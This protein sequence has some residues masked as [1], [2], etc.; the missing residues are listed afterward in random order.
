MRVRNAGAGLFLVALLALLVVGCVPTRADLSPVVDRGRQVVANLDTE[1]A[2]LRADLDAVRADLAMIGDAGVRARVVADL[3]R[4]AVLLERLQT[5]RDA[6][7]DVLAEAER[8]MA[9]APTTAAD[10]SG[11]ATAAG[12][13]IGGPAGAGLGLAGVVA[14]L[15]QRYAS[16]QTLDRL[17]GAIDDAAGPLTGVSMAD[18][19]VLRQLRQRAGPRVA[20]QVAAAVKRAR[21]ESVV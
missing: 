9:A 1:V 6:A 2:G 15:V 12:G 16:R 8:L 21:P 19:E 7:A 13:M 11:L 14:V 4:G 5:R 3:D 10:V 17:V 18:R 20:K